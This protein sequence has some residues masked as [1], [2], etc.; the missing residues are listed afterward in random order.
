M[1]DFPFTKG[2]WLEVTMDMDISEGLHLIFN[3]VI[4]RQGSTFHTTESG[5]EAFNDFKTFI[6]VIF[7]LIFHRYFQK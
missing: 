2:R 1:S 5:N 4:C 6:V 3:S 7:I